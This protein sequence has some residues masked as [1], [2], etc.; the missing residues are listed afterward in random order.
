[1]TGVSPASFKSAVATD[2]AKGPQTPFGY[3]TSGR[4]MEYLFHV[5]V[6]VV[7]SGAGTLGAVKESPYGPFLALFGKLIPPAMNVTR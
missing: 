6:R 5:V 2:H 7:G 3:V 1:M 4:G